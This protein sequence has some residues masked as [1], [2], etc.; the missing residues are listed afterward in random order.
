[1]ESDERGDRRLARRPAMTACR[2]VYSAALGALAAGC[3][4]RTSARDHAHH[5]PAVNEAAAGYADMGP[6]MRVTVKPSMRP[7]DRV[8]GE[9]IVEEARRLVAKYKDHR[10]AVEDGYKPFLPQVPL[11]EHHF[12]NYWYGFKAG[13]TFDLETPTSLLYVQDGGDYRVRGV[14]FTAPAA[15]SLAE[16]DSRVPLSLAQWHLHTAICLPPQGRGVELLR[17]NARFGFAGSIATREECEAAG[18]RFFPRLF[19]WM[20]H[21]YPGEKQLEDAFR[22]PGHHDHGPADAPEHAHAH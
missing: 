5:P 13:L 4:A 3:H 15:A 19:G 9:R 18:G 10:R 2:I 8:R 17:R 11:P 1:M 22:M 14:M 16:L 12:T 21:V 7:G 20:V 6:H